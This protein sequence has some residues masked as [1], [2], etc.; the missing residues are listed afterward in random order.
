MAAPGARAVSARSGHSVACRAVRT[1]SRRQSARRRLLARLS[2]RHAGGDARGQTGPRAGLSRAGHENPSRRNGGRSAA[3]ARPRL[4]AFCKDNQIAASARIWTRSLRRLCPGRAAPAAVA[5][6]AG[7]GSSGEEYFFNHR[8]TV[9]RRAGFQS[10][11][12]KS[13]LRRSRRVRS[14]FVSRARRRLKSE[15]Q[16]RASL[17]MADWWCGTRYTTLKA[18]AMCSREQL[19]RCSLLMAALPAELMG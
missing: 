8:G 2:G 13:F 11:H 7:A 16:A 6:A 14:F 4:R 5:V 10:C 1:G 17:P 15:I 9:A 19:R 3:P 18:W 12:H